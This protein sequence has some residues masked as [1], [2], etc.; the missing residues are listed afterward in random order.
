MKSIKVSLYQSRLKGFL[1]HPVLKRLQKEKPDFLA[2]PEYF[3]AD[4]KASK[5]S[6]QSLHQTKNLKTLTALS[7]KLPHTV[8]VGGSMATQRNGIFHNTAFIF[9]QGIQIGAYDKQNLFGREFGDITPGTLTPVFEAKGIRFAVLICADVLSDEIFEKLKALKPQL[10]M[11]PTFSPY[12]SETPEE[13]IRRDHEIFIRR[14][15]TL[16]CPIIKVCGVN[17][18]GLF[19]PIQGRSLI[20]LPDRILWRAPFHLEN[21]EIFK[22]SRLQV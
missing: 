9:Y 19:Y 18:P 3:F 1:P 15:K 7:E 12:K 8:L 4:F 14:A 10:V 6:E 5:L 16:N 22:T 21:H 17:T 20:A 13:K 2:L 11:I